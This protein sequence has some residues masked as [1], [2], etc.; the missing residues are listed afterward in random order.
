ME[1]SGLVKA[2]GGMEIKMG[3]NYYL[4]TKPCKT[5]GS[6]KKEIHIG[7]SSYGWQ[8]LFRSHPEENIFSYK[9]WLDEINDPNKEV[10]NEYGEVVSID[11]F[12]D[13]V[14]NNK[15]RSMINHYNVFNNHPQNE[16]ELE[17]VK[18]KMFKYVSGSNYQK[19]E[20]GY[21]FLL[22]EFC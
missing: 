7:K 2:V 15:R 1:K 8:F 13:C 18:G 5:C 14:E 4:R 17:Y 12:R 6:V 22:E 3:T 21:S 16:N 11:E 19:D 20:E 10:I 9:Q